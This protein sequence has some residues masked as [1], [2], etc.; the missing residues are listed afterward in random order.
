MVLHLGRAMD[1]PQQA[2]EKALRVIDSAVH[3]AE[4]YGVILALENMPYCP[5]GRYYLGA[6]YRELKKAIDLLKSPC[7]KVC[8]DWGHAN[9][10]SR[11]FARDASRG[12][13]DEYVRTFGYCRE[14]INELGPDIVYAHVHYNRSHRL[15]DEEFFEEYDEHMPLCRIPQQERGIFN[16]IISLLV[17][18]TSVPKVGLLNLELIPKRFFG[19]YQ[20]FPT[21]STRKEQF[22]SVQLL[23]EMVT[24]SLQGEENLNDNPISRN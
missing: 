24:A 5:P 10:Y 20:A 8:L 23:R 4:Q 3:L 14:I 7:V 19:F 21:G 2:L 6:D 1:P 9:N 17:H 16:D 15:G 18:R 13:I 11:F 12:P 22:E